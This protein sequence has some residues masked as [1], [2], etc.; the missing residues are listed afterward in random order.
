MSDEEEDMLE[1]I[2][3]EWMKGT[4]ERKICRMTG[5][6]RGQL[7]RILPCLDLSPDREN[8]KPA[9]NHHE[10]SVYR[11]K[12]REV[13]TQP[14]AKEPLLT[15]SK[16]ERIRDLVRCFRGHLHVTAYLPASRDYYRIECSPTQDKAVYAKYTSCEGDQRETV[17]EYWPSR[18]HDVFNTPGVALR[19]ELKG[20]DARWFDTS[21]DPTAIKKML[22]YVLRFE[23]DRSI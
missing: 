20:H 19:I 12:P 23:R 14:V 1:T 15:L 21:E 9:R 10:A 4:P 6:T 22:R 5:L 11:P 8:S 16:L 18:I 7:L 17:E 13:K 3:R 2:K